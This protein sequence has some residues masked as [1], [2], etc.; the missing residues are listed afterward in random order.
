M[1]KNPGTKH[2][3]CFLSAAAEGRTEED[4]EVK[5][6]ARADFIELPQI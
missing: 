3:F 4:G 5:S 6:S 1:R 2:Q